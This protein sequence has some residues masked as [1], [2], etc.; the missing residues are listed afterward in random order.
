MLG[1]SIVKTTG[2]PCSALTPHVQI[3]EH[4]LSHME[5]GTCT[6]PTPNLNPNPTPNSAPTPTPNPNPDPDPDPYPNPN[7]NVTLP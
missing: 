7:P 5:P 6:H 1:A 2:T 4:M 3:F